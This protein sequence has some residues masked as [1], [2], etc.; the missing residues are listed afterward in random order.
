MAIIGL[1]AVTVLMAVKNEYLIYLIRF[2]QLD[3]PSRSLA[4]PL[5][6]GAR[7]GPARASAP[8][9]VCDG[10]RLPCGGALAHWP[11]LD[12]NRMGAHTAMCAGKVL[13]L[14]SILLLLF[15]FTSATDGLEMFSASVGLCVFSAPYAQA[16]SGSSSSCTPLFTS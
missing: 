5:W 9:G 6:H 1:L 7:R 16:C 4:V 10:L 13:V 3:G 8:R 12:S 11:L 15:L 2:F 14:L